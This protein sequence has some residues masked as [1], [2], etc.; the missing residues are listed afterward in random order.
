MK[1]EGLSLLEKL[2]AIYHDVILPGETIDRKIRYFLGFATGTRVPGYPTVRPGPGI[3]MYLPGTRDISQ[4]HNFYHDLRSKTLQ[5]V[6][7]P[8]VA[9]NF[10]LPFAFEFMKV[11]KGCVNIDATHCH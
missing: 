6:A 5:H 1:I 11:A 3:E 9:Y 8:P 4:N 10:N 2:T 7:F